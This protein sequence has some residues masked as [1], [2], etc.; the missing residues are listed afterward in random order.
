MD[1]E[2]I[3]FKPTQLYADLPLPPA[4]NSIR[5]LELAPPTDQSDHEL[6]G[7][8]SVA[9]LDDRPAF[10]A[11]SYVWGQ[12]DGRTDCTVL[13]NNCVIEITPNC[14]DALLTLRR[15]H[16]TLPL[17]IWV[18]SICI[19]Q[20]NKDEKVSQIGLVKDIYTYARPVFL[21]LGPGTERTDRAIEQLHFFATQRLR[22][23]ATPWTDGHGARSPAR[24]TILWAMNLAS[25]ILQ[26]LFTSSK[27]AKFVFT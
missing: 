20:D 27:F 2:S 22:P 14:R 18:D 5:L 25:H 4:L 21:W 16:G 19:N 15:R 24:D 11:L 23:L 10:T 3:R 13:C 8:L 26:Q 1:H 7:T 17:T 9:N 12:S 6:H